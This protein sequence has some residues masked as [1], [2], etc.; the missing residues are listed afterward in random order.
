MVLA[1]ERSQLPLDSLKIQDNII[2]RLFYLYDTKIDDFLRAILH[3][4]NYTVAALP[5]G[6]LYDFT[7]LI[8]SQQ[9]S[10]IENRLHILKHITSSMR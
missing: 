6:A 4:G 9:H 1:Y 10:K 2:L 5:L 7:K 8:Y 3:I